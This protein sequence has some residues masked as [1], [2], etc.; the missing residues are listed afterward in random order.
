MVL[1][2]DGGY[3]EDDLTNRFIEFVRVSIMIMLKNIR[4]CQY[5]G[6]MIVHPE[7][8]KLKVKMDLK[9]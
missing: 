4:K 3:L 1:I 8:L 2:T 6:Y 5:I 7:R 9:L